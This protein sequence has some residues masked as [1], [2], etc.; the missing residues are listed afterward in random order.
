MT[1]QDIALRFS[2]LTSHEGSTFDVQVIPGEVEVLQIVVGGLEEVPV[3]LSITDAQILCVSYLWAEDEICQDKRVELMDTLLEM[4][5]PMPLSSFAKI[6]D[7]FAIF[8][9]MALSSS[10]DDVAHEVIVLSENTVEALVALEGY[11]I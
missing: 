6:G 2:E 5:I 10:F 4:N 1:V 8:G 9:A 7:K 11:L 3:Y